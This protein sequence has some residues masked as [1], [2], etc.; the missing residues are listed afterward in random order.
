MSW[1]STTRTVTS[2]LTQA[3]RLAAR[4]GAELKQLQALYGRPDSSRIEDFGIEAE[5]FLAA[6]YLGCVRYGFKRNGV[7]IFE[8]SYTAENASG[9]DDKPGRIP[10]GADIRSTDTWFSFMEYSTRWHQLSEA[11]R[12]AFERNLPI[13]RTVGADPTYSSGIS[14]TSAKRFSEE[15]LGLRR[16]IRSL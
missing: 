14:S 9:I 11:D 15:S 2:T 1:S 16:E 12:I 5:Q 8:L 7:V 3:R 13:Q 4:I 10:V 6:G